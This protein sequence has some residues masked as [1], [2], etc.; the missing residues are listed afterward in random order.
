MKHA[1]SSKSELQHPRLVLEKSVVNESTV[2]ISEQTEYAAAIVVE[3]QFIKLY[4]CGGL[5]PLK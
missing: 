3:N 4:A 2:T 5:L 1:P